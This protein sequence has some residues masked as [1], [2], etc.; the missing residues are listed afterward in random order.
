MKQKLYSFLLLALIG[1]LGSN[2][3]VMAQDIPEPAAQW[4]FNNADDLMAPDKGSLQM[5]PAVLGTRSVTV[6]TLSAAGIVPA[7]GPDET[8]KAIFVPATAALKVLRADGSVASQS[9]TLMLDVMVEDAAPYDGLLQTDPGNGNDGDLFIHNNTVGVGS[10]GYGGNVKNNHWNRFVLTY[11]DGKN[12]L[13]QNGDKIVEANPDNNDRFKIQPFGFYLF[14]DEDGE[15]NDTYVA[16]VA[17]WE[18]ALSAEQI[19]ALGGYKE[20]VKNFEIGTEA[21]LLAFADYVNSNREANGVLT[22]DIALSNTW[23]S[24]IG[25]DGAPFTGTFDGQGHKITGFQGTGA[26]KFGLF[27]FISN[28]TVKNFSIDGTLAVT[29]ATGTGAIGWSSA[30]RISNVHYSLKSH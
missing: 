2:V 27:G 17:F 8:N 5:I 19:K 30:S 26:G 10:L 7:D 4:N 3:Q 29:G 13:Y 11:R 14:C 28:A 6:S 15:K 22:A 25:I 18:T 12:I 21:D 20:E 9:Y 16:G 1:L 23:Q 24:P